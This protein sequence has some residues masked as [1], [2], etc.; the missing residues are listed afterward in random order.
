LLLSVGTSI[1]VLTNHDLHGSYIGTHSFCPDE[2]VQSSGNPP[3]TPSPD[4]AGRRP[5]PACGRDHCMQG[6]SHPRRQIVIISRTSAAQPAMV[7]F[8]DQT[9]C[10]WLRSLTRGFRHCFVVL[11]H[12]PRWLVCDSLKSHMEITLLDLPRSFD[13]AG[14]Y[15]EQGHHVL[16]GQTGSQVT[17]SPLAF[18]PLTCVSVAKRLLAVRAAWV[19]TPRQLFCHLLSTQP[20]TWQ[21]VSG[22]QLVPESPDQ[23][24]IGA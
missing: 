15:A 17:R 22:G 18:A 9:E 16:V 2:F 19:C 1:C 12:G 7:V 8:V 23:R 6:C 3:T 24:A 13:L 4:A 11:R 20:D 10:R 21:V 14:C 5:G